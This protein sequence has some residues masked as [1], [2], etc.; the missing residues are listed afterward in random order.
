MN[1]GS[2]GA[3]PN[4]SGAV[5]H[6]RRQQHIHDGDRNNQPPHSY[7]ANV[8]VTLAAA[9]THVA[10]TLA[11]GC[12]P[13]PR[14]PHIVQLVKQQ[15]FLGSRHQGAV[16]LLHTHTHTRHDTTTDQSINQPGSG[17][18]HVRQHAPTEDTTLRVGWYRG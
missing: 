9:N 7:N 8:V 5:A 11:V 16:R 18:A 4:K 17:G 12:S 13:G 10:V 2:V 15:V 1:I 14:G 3:R 6:M